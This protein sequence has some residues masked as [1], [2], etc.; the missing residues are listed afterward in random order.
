M[1]ILN[2][3]CRRSSPGLR[4]HFHTPT[5]APAPRTHSA[6]SLG[7]ATPAPDWPSPPGQSAYANPPPVAAPRALPEPLSHN[8]T[9]GGLQVN[10]IP[11][12]LNDAAC[13]DHSAIPRA[14]QADLVLTPTTQGL[15]RSL[16]V[17]W[18][19]P[20]MMLIEGPTSA[21]KTAAVRYLAWKTQA[22]YRRINLSDATEVA[23]LIGRYV[24]G[25]LRYSSSALQ[26]MSATD[27]RLLCDH[28]KVAAEPR[29]AS[30]A[31]LVQ[32][33]QK[34]RWVDGPVVTALK[35]GEVLLL[36]EI[37]LAP[38]SVI[39]RINS[40]LDDDGNLVLT[41]HKGEVIAPNKN[42]R[43]VSTCNPANYVGRKPLSEAFRSRCTLLRAQALTQQDLVQI[44]Q[45]RFAGALPQQELAKLVQTHSHL[46]NM[47]E[48]H[49]I[50]RRN[51]GMAYTL[52]DLMKV[53]ARFV[54]FRD[55]GL[56]QASLLRRETEEVYSGGLVDEADRNAVDAVLKTTMPCQ[57]PDFYSGLQLSEDATSFTLGDVRV[58]KLGLQSAGVPGEAAR[59]VLTDRTKQ[60]FYRMVKALEM[61]ENVAL[62][63]ERASGKTALARMYSHLRGQPYHRQQFSADTD[64]QQLIG[65]Y[66]MEGWNDG[67][68][69]TAGRPGTPGV[70][71]ADELNLGSP[72]LLERLNPVLDDEKRL[73]LA[74]REG[75]SVRLDPDFRFIAA[76]NPVGRNNS[77][78]VRLS[79]AMHNRF[80]QIYVP[81]PDGAAELSQIAISMGA[82]LG[83]PERVA[84][85]A[86]AFH[87]QIIQAYR[88]HSLGKDLR[89]QERP[90]LSLRQLIETLAMTAD[91]QTLFGP[92]QAWLLAVESQYAAQ[93][94][95]ADRVRI[96]GE[97]QAALSAAP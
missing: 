14:A 54:H 36:D 66:D 92:D 91:L 39:E 58:R 29:N 93:A 64:A 42:F 95:Y 12:Q 96:E 40:L 65:G 35:R 57:N 71:L 9:A 52:R 68:L 53:G 61:G 5:P 79:A 21:G 34:S 4:T 55:N 78:R 37:N 41:E 3:L 45:S 26:A 13:K 20:R 23:D 6:T 97:A 63:G 62:I 15:L 90:I 89:P 44:M 38:A 25:E 88:D 85:R 22:P 56:D 27:L 73:V 18:R 30:I 60:M 19:R 50:G 67:L 17:A 24:G 10:G 49:L 70:Y 2:N 16:A 94:H 82:R 80:T 11:L 76:M 43:V 28:Y 7:D 75:E 59:L 87:L 77:G 81:D 31:A 47:A 46:A 32:A 8:A 86:V 74:E 72:A 33:Q 51:D 83:V 69:L 1:D 48:R 84:E